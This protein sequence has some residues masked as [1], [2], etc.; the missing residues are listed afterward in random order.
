MRQVDWLSP[1]GQKMQAH[2]K[3]RKNEREGGHEGESNQNTTKQPTKGCDLGFL[4]FRGREKLE[5]GIP[6]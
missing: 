6:K 4:G 2:E 1:A 5:A 3:V